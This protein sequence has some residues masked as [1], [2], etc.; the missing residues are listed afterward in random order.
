MLILLVEDNAEIAAYV[1]EGLGALG[2]QVEIA[3]DGR[4]GL[5]RASD[6]DFDCLVVASSWTGLN[7]AFGGLD[8]RSTS[9]G[10]SSSSWRSCC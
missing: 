2:H 8:V 3:A 5:T 10:A 9:R 1:G 7:G 4:S 6:P